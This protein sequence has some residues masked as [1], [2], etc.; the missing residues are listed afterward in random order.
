MVKRFENWHSFA[1][2]MEFEFSRSQ[3]DRLRNY[4]NLVATLGQ[5]CACTK[6]SRS[7]NALK[8]YLVIGE[9]LTEDNANLLRGKYPNHTI[10]FA[11]D[12]AVFFIIQPQ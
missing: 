4:I 1:K 2:E 12:G 10:E 3:N 5:G 8:E 11:Q 9:Y 7:E 6:R